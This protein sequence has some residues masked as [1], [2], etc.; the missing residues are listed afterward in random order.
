MIFGVS[1]KPNQSTISGAIATS[2]RVWLMMNS[3]NRALR[4]GLKKS[5]SIERMKAT[6]SEQAKPANVALIVGT[7]L[8]NSAWR[9]WMAW[10]RTRDGAG[11]VVGEMPERRA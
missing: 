10:A 9:C 3:G 2:G 6:A 4:S 1:P 7:V 8:S 5:I 11:S